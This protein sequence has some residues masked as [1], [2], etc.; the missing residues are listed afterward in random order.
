MRRLVA[1]HDGALVYGANF[2]IGVNVFYRMVDA[3]GQADGRASISM[4]RSSKR[5]ITRAN[6]TRLPAR[7]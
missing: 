3:R 1:E 7:P 6:A 2:S 5:N 4:R